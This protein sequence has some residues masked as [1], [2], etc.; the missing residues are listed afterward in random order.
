LICKVFETI[1]P[2]LD[3]IMDAIQSSGLAPLE[4]RQVVTRVTAYC[5]AMG[6]GATE[7]VDGVAGS[8]TVHLAALRAYA[9]HVLRCIESNSDEVRQ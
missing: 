3:E 2:A 1:E 7:D 8:D 4:I 9:E 6:V 5:F